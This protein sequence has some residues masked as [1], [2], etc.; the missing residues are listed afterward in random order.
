MSQETPAD[1]GITA[2]L[3]VIGEE[4]LSGRTHDTNTPYIADYLTRAGISLREVRVIADIE[5]EIAGTVN[6][7]RGR[8]TY[9]FTTGGIGPTHDDV[10]T[11][12]MGKAFNAAVCLNDEAVAALGMKYTPEELTPAR[13]RMARIPEG[14]ALIHNYVSRAPGYMIGNVVVMAGIPAVMHAMLDEVLPRLEKGI[15]VQSRSVRVSARESEVAAPLAALQESFADVQMGSYPFYDHQRFG[16]YLVLRSADDRRLTEALDA[17]W[18]L[19][20]CSRWFLASCAFTNAFSASSCGLN[21]CSPSSS[22][23]S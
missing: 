2:A 9:V 8:Y 20:G 7:L 3:I 12:A 23:R 14:A 11:D 17:L 21:G 13:L 22:S 5:E 1:V 10:T 16:T 4:I 18:Q 15:P 19:P 6:A